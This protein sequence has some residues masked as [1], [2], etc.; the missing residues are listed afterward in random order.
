MSKHQLAT[1]RLPIANA[2]RIGQVRVVTDRNGKHYI[3]GSRVIEII[4][5]GT[6]TTLKLANG[7]SYFVRT[8]E[9]QDLS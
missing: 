2:T 4:D 5:H 3:D 7:T 9:Y 1:Y 6:H 8:K